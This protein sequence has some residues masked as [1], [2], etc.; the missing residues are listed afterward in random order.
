MKIIPIEYSCGPVI[1]FQEIIMFWWK[2]IVVTLLV[3]CHISI[4]ILVKIDA[5]SVA[6][7]VG[8]WTV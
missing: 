5:V 4:E 6:P 8:I 3:V 7:E 2:Q 1:T